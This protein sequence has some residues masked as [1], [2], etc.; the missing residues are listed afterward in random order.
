MQASSLEVREWRSNEACA[1]TEAA[2]LRQVIDLLVKEAVSEDFTIDT[3][4]YKHHPN[5]LQSDG[6]NSN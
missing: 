2:E 5:V 3:R 1:R 4:F 6:Q